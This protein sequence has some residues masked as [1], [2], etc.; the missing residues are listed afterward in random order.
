MLTLDFFVWYFCYAILFIY[1]QK[2]LF[3]IPYNRNMYF[4]N[5]NFRNVEIFGNR[6]QMCRQ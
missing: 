4:E 6:Q 5:F 3:E 1:K 2:C